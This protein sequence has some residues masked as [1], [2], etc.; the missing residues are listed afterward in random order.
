MRRHHH[1]IIV[2]ALLFALLTLSA[3]G[4]IPALPARDPGPTPTPLV[5]EGIA[6]STALA[7]NLGT[8]PITQSWSTDF[9]EI[10]IPLLGAISVPDG[11]GPFPTALVLHGR[12]SRC[13][14]DEA[15]VDEVWPCEEGAEPRYDIG[16]SYLLDSLAERGYLAIAPSVNGAY[17]TTYDLGTGS[18]DEIQPHVDERMIAIIQQHL[19]RIAA[20]GDGEQ[21]FAGGLDLT[22]KVDLS[23]VAVVAHSVSGITA[24]KIARE[25]L[26]PVRAQVLL[27]GMHFDTTGATADVPTI[28]V[29]SACD[30]DSPGLPVQTYYETARQT[31]RADALFSTMLEGAN[32]NFYNQELE[33]QGIDDGPFSRNPTCA[34]FRI[35]ASEQQSFLTS[36][37]G[38]YFDVYFMDADRPQWLDITQPA[39]PELYG[40]QVQNALSPPATQRRTLLTGQPTIDGQIRASLCTLGE[41]CAAGLFQPGLPDSVRLSWEAEGAEFQVDLSTVNEPFEALRLRVAVDPMDPLNTEGES[42]SFS[43]VLTDMAGN[44]AA[45]ALPAPLPFVPKGTYEGDD[46]RFSPVLPVDIRLSLTDFEGVDTTSLA[47]AALRF[48]NNPTGSV[49]VVDWDLVHEP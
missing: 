5:T 40:R 1:P 9:P 15:Q 42:V 39:A 18:L 49:L 36:L 25:S 3:C 34:Q 6:G 19:T 30:G 28:T 20:A 26:L 37:A 38:D 17:T 22:G 29:L 14:S 35:S 13:Y 21:V 11:E 32:H 47:T 12:H 33:R 45:L 46:Y 7:Y 24:N 48:D 8:V 44:S 31:G 27:A 43:V 10:P 2:P 4:F 16:F 41:A 23:Q